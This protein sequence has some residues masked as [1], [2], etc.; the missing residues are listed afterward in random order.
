MHFDGLFGHENLQKMAIEMSVPADK[1]TVIIGV[2]VA[3]ET[4]ESPA[5]WQPGTINIVR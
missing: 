1:T 2:R 3:C 4:C 5:T